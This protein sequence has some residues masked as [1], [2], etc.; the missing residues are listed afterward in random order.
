MHGQHSPALPPQLCKLVLLLG[1]QDKAEKPEN[2]HKHTER[3]VSLL[4]NPSNADMLATAALEKGL[5]WGR[6]HQLMFQFSRPKI[7]SHHAVCM[8]ISPP[9][10]TKQQVSSRGW[11]HMRMHACVQAVGHALGQNVHQ[12]ANG[13]G[14]LLPGVERLRPARAGHR[15]RRQHGVLRGPAPQPR[16]QDRQAQPAGAPGGGALHQTL[17]NLKNLRC[18]VLCRHGGSMQAAPRFALPVS[19]QKMCMPLTQLWCSGE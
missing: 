19:F 13:G 12:G 17:K 8:V 3:L 1:E 16:L 6:F 7:L 5:R 11:R 9:S 14:Q 10:S 4:W 2:E 15:Q 18:K